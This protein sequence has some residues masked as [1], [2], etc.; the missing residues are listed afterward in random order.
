MPHRPK[1]HA[2][3]IGTRTDTLKQADA[4]RGTA[5]SRGYNYD[6]Q[7]AASAFKREHPFCRHCLDEGVYTPAHCVDHVKPHRGDEALFWDRD[8]WQSLCKR[9]HDQKTAKGE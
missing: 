1:S 2:E 8:N 7:L 4:R 9:H 6:W 5:H 3:K